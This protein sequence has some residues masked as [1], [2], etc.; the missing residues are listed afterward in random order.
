MPGILRPT[1]FQGLLVYYNLQLRVNL[2][3]Y[4]V[5]YVSDVKEA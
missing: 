4:Y 2:K 5:S 1:R 3:C